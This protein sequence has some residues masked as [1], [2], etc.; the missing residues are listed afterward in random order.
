MNWELFETR[1]LDSSTCGC[2]L[3]THDDC[4]EEW[5]FVAKWKGEPR[6]LPVRQEADGGCPV[7]YFEDG[8]DDEDIDEAW[9]G[10]GPTKSAAVKN[11]RW[12][13]KQPEE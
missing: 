10:H 4:P 9:W 1:E 8:T 13:V 12:N 11:C 2:S 3:F 5:R 7:F 6:P